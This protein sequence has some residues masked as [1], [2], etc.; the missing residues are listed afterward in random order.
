MWKLDLKPQS[1]ALLALLILGKI[2]LICWR[3]SDWEMGS[4]CFQGTRQSERV[5]LGCFVWDLVGRLSKMKLQDDQSRLAKSP[6]ALPSKSH[7]LSDGIHM[8]VRAVQYNLLFWVFLLC[9]SLLNLSLPF[10]GLGDKS[11][12]FARRSVYISQSST[13]WIWI[14]FLDSLF[15]PGFGQIDLL[16][17]AWVLQGP[18][19]TGSKTC[20]R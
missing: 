7:S 1:W 17:V 9:F 14:S 2:I 18:G 4:D 15:F 3:A 16:N 13:I 6:L 11:T 5:Y 10:L 19:D 20:T 8:W 12:F